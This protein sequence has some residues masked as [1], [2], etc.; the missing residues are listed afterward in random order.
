MSNYVKIATVGPGYPELSPKTK[1]QDVVDYMI[2]HWRNEFA[3]VLSD[4]PD[5]IVVP[6]VCDM[7]GEWSTERSLEYYKVR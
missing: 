3:Q 2:D 4:K 5:L 7:P 1:P 6:E